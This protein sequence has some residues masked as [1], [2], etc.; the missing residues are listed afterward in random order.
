MIGIDY[1]TKR[2]GLAV[3]DPLQMFASPLHTYLTGEVLTFLVQYAKE[4]EIEGFVV[5]MPL[6][7]RGEDTHSTNYVRNFVEELRQKFPQKAIHLQDERFTSSIAVDTLI[8][9]GMKK[10]DRRKK[11][12]ID[13][14]SAAIILQSYLESKTRS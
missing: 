2:V 14:V 8:R 7:L 9:G 1:G 4:E 6:N 3:T 11:E 12:N 10:K 5:G 13:K